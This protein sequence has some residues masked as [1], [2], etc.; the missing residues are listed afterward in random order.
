ARRAGDD[1]G[2]RGP[3]SDRDPLLRLLKHMSELIAENT[4]E[5][6]TPD[7]VMEAAAIA[8]ED[9]VSW[10]LV[11]G[12]LWEQGGVDLLSSAFAFGAGM[13]HGE[14][15]LAGLEALDQGETTEGNR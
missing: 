12:P 6:P 10:G 5:P 14:W 9:T 3:V 4:G 11:S 7:S 1:R 8:A 15:L 13:N 2:R